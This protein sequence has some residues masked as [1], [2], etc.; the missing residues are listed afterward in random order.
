MNSVARSS[1]YASL[2][3]L[4]MLEQNVLDTLAA[5]PFYSRLRFFTGNFQ[6]AQRLPERRNAK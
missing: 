5:P 3:L 2:F 4:E 6:G 1:D